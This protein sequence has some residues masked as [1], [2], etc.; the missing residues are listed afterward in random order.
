VRAQGL[1]PIDLDVRAGEI[2]VLAGIDGNGQGPFEELLAG[3][4][5]K[6]AGSLDVLAPPLAVL[7]GDRQRTGLVL[8]LSVEENLVLSETAR[9]A[10][11]SEVFRLGLVR[12]RALRD[13]ARQAI[14]R[15]AIRADPRDLVATLSGGNQQKLCVARALRARPGVLVAVNPTRGLDRGAASAVREE[16]RVQARGGTAVLLVSS[17]LDEGFEL[18]HRIAVWFRGELLDAGPAPTRERIGRLMLGERAA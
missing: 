6:S 9:G 13:A 16:L 4:R 10:G 18:G 17:D 11:P 14:D 12:P 3:V 2:V 1:G 15:F 5:A 8:G 7:P